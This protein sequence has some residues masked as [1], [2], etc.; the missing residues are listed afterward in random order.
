M[1]SGVIVLFNIV[2]YIVG[3]VVTIGSAIYLIAVLVI[4]VLIIQY[5][6]SKHAKTHFHK[7]V[8]LRDAITNVIKEHYAE[9]RSDNK[10]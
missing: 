1:V 3:R 5:L 8:N 4:N 7:E 10:K 2:A 6:F 9:H